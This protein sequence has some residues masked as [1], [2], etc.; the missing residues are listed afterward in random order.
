MNRKAIGWY[1]SNGI[2]LVYGGDQW[3]AEHGNEPF[4]LRVS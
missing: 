2:H 4:R 3:R 1:V